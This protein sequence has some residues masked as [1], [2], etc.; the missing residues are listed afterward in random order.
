MRHKPRMKVR[1]RNPIAP[2]S[3]KMKIAPIPDNEERRLA[4]LRQLA[5]MDTPDEDRF[6][7]ITRLAAR[8]LGAPIAAVSLV[9]SSRQWLKSVVGLNARETSRD[10]AFCAHTILGEDTMVVEDALADERFV[11]NPL[12]LGAP[13]IRFYA[14]HPLRAN[15][16]SAVGSLCIIGPQ[17]RSLT[18]EDQSILEDLAQLAERELNMMTLR[19]AL[20]QLEESTARVSEM[21]RQLHAIASSAHMSIIT[22]QVDGTV[23]MFN[24]TAE[25][26]L[27]Y[28]AEET[29]G[30]LRI[31]HFYDPTE[32]AAPGAIQSTDQRCA[33]I[34]G[35]AIAHG[36]EERL[37]TYVRKD[38]SRFPVI[39]V[40]TALRSDSGVIQGF[41]VL[42][43]D[44]TLQKKAEEEMDRARQ[45]A[46][47]ANQA[48]SFFL[49]HMSHEVRTPL[50]GI[51]GIN[52]ML[53]KTALDH[54]QRGLAKIIESSAETLLT[55]VNDILDF[56]KVEA[57]KLELERADFQLAKLLD[58]VRNLYGPTASA[59][60]LI[61]DIECDPAIPAHLNGDPT[62]L[63]Q[64]I[65][66]LVSNAIKFSQRGRV[67]VSLRL[68][69]ANPDGVICFR[70]EV[71]D[72]GLGI[73][74]DAQTRIFSPFTQADSSTT[75]QSG[76]TGLGLTICRQLVELMNG[77]IGVTS[78]LGQGSTFWFVVRLH[79]ALSEH[80]AERLDPE[81]ERTKAFRG[82]RVLVAEDNP[83]NRI[84][85]VHHLEALECIVAT[86]N[87][88]LAAVYAVQK[89][90][91]DLI[92]MDCQMP[93]MDGYEA[94]AL[95]RQLPGSKGKIKVIALTANALL[96]EKDRCTSAGMDGYLSKPFSEA[97]LEK[98]MAR[99]LSDVVVP[100]P[101][102]VSVR[103]E[104]SIDVAV[105]DELRSEFNR[106]SGFLS[107]AQLFAME[108][109]ETMARIEQATTASQ[110][111]A[112]THH[113]R[114]SA[115]NFGAIKLAKLSVS[116]EEL[117]ALGKHEEAKALI[118]PIREES[119]RVVQF[120]LAMAE[121]APKA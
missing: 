88:G 27:G 58:E 82:M 16:G 19:H 104:S 33:A 8:V 67:R 98:V 5:I 43:R 48:K 68:E 70:C 109:G 47:R 1:Q 75:R 42:A 7:R 111:T 29:L 60:G 14:G 107:F 44:V 50:N 51:I 110:L 37:C 46:E 96:D 30:K 100:E 95:I 79:R 106:A 20:D 105:L 73:S 69:S 119:E 77:E 63:R 89:S 55:I 113:L 12:V 34:F 121:R 72:S 116:I 18:R 17:P 74:Q 9:D 114:G 102:S 13:M 84:I 11:D 76:G 49:A 40:T 56:S 59:K 53:L 80:V 97:D 103:E 99:V 23:R 15:D 62:R 90:D 22:T 61:L 6:D 78:E 66:N 39:A 41:I 36:S 57:G 118:L 120:V 52:G 31:D 4:A 87:D 86:E 35:G 65:D 21:G 93:C 71:T 108:V 85:A 45:T 94:T 24:S 117:V 38:G 115:L 112:A 28:E 3:L 26:W 32:L 83:I 92:L 10:V 54:E 101:E 2:E 64:V 25:R 81:R 91:F